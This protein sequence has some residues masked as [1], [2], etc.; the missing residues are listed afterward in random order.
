MHPT[1]QP[2]STSRRGGL[3]FAPLDSV[4][5]VESTNANIATVILIPVNR[6]RFLKAET[7]V[8]KLNVDGSSPFTRFQSD[9]EQTTALGSKPRAA[10]HWAAMQRRST[11]RRGGLSFTDAQ[12]KPGATHRGTRCRRATARWRSLPKSLFSTGLLNVRCK[13]MFSMP[14]LICVVSSVFHS[15]H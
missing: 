14:P 1:H 12:P 11:S 2:A 4:D 13:R 6:K 3:S 15:V 5:A 8:P 10:P 9:D 7:E